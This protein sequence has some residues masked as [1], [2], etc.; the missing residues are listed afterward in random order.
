MQTE[1]IQAWT[2]ASLLAGLFNAL[3]NSV[4]AWGVNEWVAVLGVIGMA[5][6]LLMQRHYNRR[7]DRRE[8]EKHEWERQ[9]FAARSLEQEPD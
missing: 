1:Q 4:S 3:Y 6:S 7:R 5:F 9:V 8:A 2:L